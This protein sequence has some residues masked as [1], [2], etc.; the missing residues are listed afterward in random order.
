M[1]FLGHPSNGV[2]T[3]DSP[4]FPPDKFV[5][6]T[7][8]LGETTSY[9]APGF[10]QGVLEIEGRYKIKDIPAE[11]IDLCKNLRQYGWHGLLVGGCVRD[12][13]LNEEIPGLNIPSKD[14]DIEVYGASA[15]EL[16]HFLQQKYPEKNINLVGKAF[17]IYK[18]Y[19]PGWPEPLDI[20]IPREDNQVGEGHSD[21]VV[22]GKPDM[23]I[24]E[25]GMRRDLKMNT[26]AYDPLTETLYDP[27]GGIENIQK[28]II[29]VTDIEAF[30]ED[31]LRVLRVM[32]FMARFEMEASEETV[33]L[34]RE[35]IE[36]GQL[37]NLSGERVGEEF[38][39]L[40]E[41]GRKPSLGLEFARKI[42]YFERYMPEIHALTEFSLEKRLA[43][44]ED[45]RATNMAVLEEKGQID[46]KK[47]GVVQEADFHPEG[48]LWEHTLQT[49]DAAVQVYD[50]VLANGEYPDALEILHLE[51]R[52]NQENSSL[53]LDKQAAQDR[54]Q[55][56]YKA[57]LKKLG[58]DGRVLL[59]V[60]SL[61]HDLGKPSTTEYIDGAW[62]SRGHEPAGI[63]P[64]KQFLTRLSNT[65]FSKELKE[66]VPPLVAY[67][68]SPPDF[69]AR[70]GNDQGSQDAS[71]GRMADRLNREGAVSLYMLSWVAEADQRGRNPKGKDENHRPLT[72]EECSSGKEKETE[73]LETWQPWLHKKIED[74]KLYEKKLTPLINGGQVMEVLDVNT[75]E[76][77]HPYLGVVIE[78]L[79]LDQVD[80]IITTPEQAKEAAAQYYSRLSA[81]LEQED[82]QPVDYWRKV[83]SWHNPRIYP[84][85]EQ[86]K[87]E[88]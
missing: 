13:V 52:L 83:K 60:A 2:I 28:R 31:P 81:Q 18:V 33:K 63:E 55:R 49:V 7:K 84:Q 26:L 8:R 88:D 6:V 9:K 78:C 38:R 53:K 65:S 34:C 66:Q 5:V 57:E 36:R 39:K 45:L 20:S 73:K 37:D 41:K 14:F 87:A 23:T 76:K 47:T 72:W 69:L 44:E 17:G 25:A 16:H 71:I 62:R 15:E 80:G 68:L 42:G 4:Q 56:R 67:H 46:W 30:Q 43:L 11:V 50:R 21:V 82:I 27:Y 58:K 51:E 79:R 54:Y 77:S 3:P 85:P 75:R 29:E 59:A 40:F 1:S 22:S 35:M 10:E 32:Q 24:K 74:L 12:A 61:C 48:N 86:T 64:T 19:I 70:A